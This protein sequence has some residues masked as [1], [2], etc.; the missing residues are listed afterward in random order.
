MPVK[1]HAKLMLHLYLLENKNKR[2]AS[3]DF[4]ESLI[5]SQLH[6]TTSVGRSKE[7]ETIE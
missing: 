3:A 4:R 7:Q 6:I 1:C 5:H 2:Q